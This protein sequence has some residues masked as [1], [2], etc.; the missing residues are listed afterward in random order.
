MILPR[1]L[2]KVTTW[3]DPE[4]SRYA[5]GGVR[6]GRQKDKCFAE[7]TDGRRL[8]LLEWKDKGPE[9]D[10][11]LDGK[12]LGRAC[13][14]VKRGQVVMAES[15]NG[16]A[17]VGDMAV[18]TIQGRWPR[19]ED[20]LDPAKVGSEEATFTVERLLQ[21]ANMIDLKVGDTTVKLNATFVR[22]L[23]ETA[24]AVGSDKVR[25]RASDA[26]SAVTCDCAHGNVEMTAVIMPM[27]AD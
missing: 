24:K 23:A 26:Q 9:T 19:T 10:A 2:A 15:P 5:L 17:H 8:V 16:V 6:I 7:A 22:E 18:P 25:I 20:V 27:A 12:K 11:I 1:S 4:S 14:A 3:A 21:L 13:R